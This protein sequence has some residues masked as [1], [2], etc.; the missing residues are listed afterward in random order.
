M[1]E[2]P[3]LFTMHCK[4]GA[5]YAYGGDREMTAMWADDVHFATPE[6]A[7]KHWSDMHGHPMTN[8]EK[9]KSVFGAG[10]INKAIATC[11]WWAEPY[12][13]EGEEDDVYY[14]NETA[15]F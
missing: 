6:E 5:R 2:E 9:F 1:I 4:N 8:M 7:M 11:S 15:T 14:G 12:L 13:D 3:R 10:A